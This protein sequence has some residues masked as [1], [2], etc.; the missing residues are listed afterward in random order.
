MLDL[1]LG[2]HAERGALL[3]GEGLVVECF[4]RTRRPQ[5]DDDVVTAFD[6]EAEREDNAF[7]RVVGIGDVLALAETER[8]L[9][10]LQ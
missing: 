7:A 10:L 8:G 3:D 1:E 4:E 5:I 2:L 9:P 6:L